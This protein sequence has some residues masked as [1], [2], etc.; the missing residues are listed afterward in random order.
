MCDL[1]YGIL[2]R[3]D[4]FVLFI[5]ENNF[6][7]YMWRRMSEILGK[8]KTRHPN[9]DEVHYWGKWVIFC[10]FFILFFSIILVRIMLKKIN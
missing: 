6:Y 7:I 10:L 1:S 4:T 2:G 5:K 9:I 3:E 8:W